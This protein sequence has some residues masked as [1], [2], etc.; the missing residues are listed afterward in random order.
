MIADLCTLI[1]IIGGVALLLMATVPIVAIGK[2]IGD[3]WR[4]V[5]LGAYRAD[6]KLWE[7]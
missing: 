3:A 1:L 5:T 6:R 4:R 7:K 2:R